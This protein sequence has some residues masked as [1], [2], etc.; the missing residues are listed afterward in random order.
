[1]KFIISAGYK[2]IDIDVLA[3][4]LAL[5]ELIQLRG[6]QS[7]VHLTGPF[8][9]T[10]PT[11]FNY[12]NDKEI[13]RHAPLKDQDYRFILVD[14]SNPQHIESFV[15]IDQVSAVYDHHYGF[16][17]FWR[18]RL[19]KQAKINPIG[20]CATLIWEEFKSANYFDK[21]SPSSANLLYTAIISNTLNFNAQ[22]SSPR[23]QKAANEL[24]NYT[25]LPKTW[26]KQ[27][28][29]EIDNLLVQ[30]MKGFLQKDTKKVSLMDIN[31]C[32][33][34]LEVWNAASFL[35]HYNFSQIMC[36]IFSEQVWL[37][38]LISIEERCSY[39]IANSEIIRNYINKNIKNKWQSP[40][41]K[42]EHLWMRKE[43]LK[44]LNSK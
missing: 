8:N 2:Y 5:N 22:I 13:I 14:I 41:F 35:D 42:T 31:L 25:T 32:F 10:I 15:E 30:D 29:Q 23:D 12:W 44:L 34:Q 24:L 3:S 36:E 26:I 17:E 20:A 18:N 7:A 38:N 6:E 27:Y 43:I 40:Y 11:R 1:M 37:L 19:G 16:E 4:S 9:A 28:Y 39:L 21:I 33:S